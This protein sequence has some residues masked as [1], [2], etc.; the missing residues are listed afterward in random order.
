MDT[1]IEK[2]YQ[3]V[4]EVDTRFIRS[5]M[6]KIDWSDRLIGIRGARGV[7]KTT[8]L[9][10]RIKKFLGNTNE[11]LYVSLDNLWFTE[12]SLLDLVDY[13]VKRGGKY[14]FLDEVHKY[15]KW[16]QAIKNIYDDFSDLKVVFTGSSLLEILNA[17]ADLSRRAIVYDIQGLSY[18]EFLNITQKTDFQEVT[19]SDIIKNHKELSDE[20]LS[21]VKPLQFFNDY[22]QHGYYP[23][24][25]E[26]LAK[27]SYRL[28]EIVNLILEVELPLLRNVEPA[29]VPKI[30]Q[31]LQIIAESF[32]FI[33]NIDNLS[34]RIDIHRNT[35]LSYLYNLEETQLT[36]HLHKDISGINKLQKPEKIYLE[37]TNLAYTLAENNTNIGNMR[38]TFFLNQLSYAH[39]VEYPNTG[40]FWVESKYLF[41]IGGKNKTG[42]QI[43]DSKNALIVSDNIEYGFGNKIPLWMFGLLY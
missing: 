43:K 31:L 39:T 38:E 14:L 42:K 35:L 20:I 24:F 36:A 26:G 21:K 17:R 12:H 8:L 41:E 30:K 10:Q 3:K 9:L 34:K 29:Y 23:F 28:E 40:D 19:L 16:S 37:N 32:P 22:L 25:T 15:P 4:R 7:G 1:L 33:P 18:R 13:F 5:I 27:F 2:S 6:Q 11:V